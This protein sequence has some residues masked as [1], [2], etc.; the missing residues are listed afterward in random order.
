MFCTSSQ[1]FL[2]TVSIKSISITQMSYT[3]RLSYFRINHLKM[4]C[5]RLW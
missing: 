4:V 5:Y 3:I 1:N 2:V